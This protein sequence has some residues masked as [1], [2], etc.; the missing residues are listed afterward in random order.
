MSHRTREKATR[1]TSRIQQDLAWR[2]VDPVRHE[3]CKGA[4]RVVLACV[5]G[6]LEISE[7][8]LIH[9]AKVLACGEVVEV[10]LVNLVGH[11]AEE[12]A[13]FHVVVGIFEDTTN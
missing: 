13:R 10:D 11:L 12:L 4:W 6:A 8:L 7:D 3:C 2:W 1:A 9:V 5:A